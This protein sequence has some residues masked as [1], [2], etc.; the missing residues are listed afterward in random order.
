MCLPNIVGVLILLSVVKRSRYYYGVNN[1]AILS[2]GCQ[3]NFTTT[4]NGFDVT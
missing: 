4:S 1:S 3:L 2:V